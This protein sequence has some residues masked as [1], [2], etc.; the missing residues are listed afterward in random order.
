MKLKVFISWSGEMGREVAFRLKS[1][2]PDVMSEIEQLY[3]PDMDKGV[4]CGS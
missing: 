1:W 3:S 2:L 4:R